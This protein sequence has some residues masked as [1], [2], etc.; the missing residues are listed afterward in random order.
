MVA[1]IPSRQ[2]SKLIAKLPE[3]EVEKREQELYRAALAV[4]QDEGP[5]AEMK[6]R[7]V[8][9]GDGME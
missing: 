7:D 6:D 2:K 9:F 4:E 8:T 3:D 5:G 1:A